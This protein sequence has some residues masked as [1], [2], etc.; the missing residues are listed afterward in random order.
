MRNYKKADCVVIN[1]GELENELRDRS[2][3]LISLTKK[4]SLRNKIKSLVVTQGRRGAI[5]FDKKSN[6]TH[7]SLALASKVIDKVGAGDAFLSIISLF[8]KLNVQK[9]LSLLAG[10]LAAAQSTE[11]IGNKNAVNKIKLLKSIEHIL[12]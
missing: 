7:K 12:K 11:D 5:L 4:L 8:L 2:K 3:D 1:Q 9:D 6:K 10:S